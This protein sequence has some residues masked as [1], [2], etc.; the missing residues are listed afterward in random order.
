MSW[1][2]EK[3]AK[4]QTVG[5]APAKFL[6][7]VISTF[8]DERHSCFPS[9][10]LLA[11][12]TEMSERS[13]RD[14]LNRLDDLGLLKRERDWS[15]TKKGITRYVLPV[16]EQNSTS[17]AQEQARKRDRQNLPHEQIETGKSNVSDRQIDRQNL[18]TNLKEQ[19]EEPIEREAAPAPIRFRPIVD[20]EAREAAFQKFLRPEADGGYPAEGIDDL[21]AA[22]K[23]WADVPEEAWEAGPEAVQRFV[24][25]RRKGRRSII[26]GLTKYI[27]DRHWER[28]PPPTDTA[29]NPVDERV[30]ILPWSRAAW[31]LFARQY[32][33]GKTVVNT[34]QWIRTGAEIQVSA[35]PGE[36]E[37]AALASIAVGS[38]E[39]V[40]WRDH[41]KRLGFD[42]PMP[43][44]AEWIFLP[45]KHP[46]SLSMSWKGYH[47]IEDVPVEVRGPAWWWVVYQ[48]QAPVANLLADRTIGTRRLTMGPVP[49]PREVDEMVRIEIGSPE[50][51]KWDLWFAKHGVSLFRLQ[52]SIWAPTRDP[53]AVDAPDPVPDYE[54]IGRVL[55]E[56][57]Q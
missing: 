10:Q 18:P 12:I 17:W 19:P 45:S 14:N 46:R 11:E 33:A 36:D 51:E 3:W 57:A 16:A 31:A 56:A 15:S 52:G 44:K 27:R 9:Q 54:A 4:D 40:A 8:C 34:I 20:E 49:L 30:R 26:I 28:F 53:P 42:L 6:L 41:C 22:R 47:T 50:F 43:D 13:V 37:T 1:D 55:G 29:G 23:A 2:T 35:A 48:P 39:H 7:I 25:A 21:E 32:V 24:R 38:P 5:H